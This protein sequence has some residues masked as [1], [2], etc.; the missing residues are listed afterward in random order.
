ME[1]TV[2]QS[3][4]GTLT[5]TGCPNAPVPYGDVARSVLSGR[6]DTFEVEVVECMVFHANRQTFDGW[7]ESRSLGDG[8]TDQPTVNFET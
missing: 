3:L 7:I 6:Q 8:P 2:R 5:R 1:S 4:S